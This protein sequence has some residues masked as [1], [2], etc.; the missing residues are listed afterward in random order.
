MLESKKTAVHWPLDIH[1]EIAEVFVVNRIST[2]KD[3]GTLWDKLRKAHSWPEWYPNS[4][5]VEI[6]NRETPLLNHGST[7]VWETHGMFWA[8]CVIEE[9]DEKEKRLAWRAALNG[10]TAYHAWIFRENENGTAE[11]IT[12]EC[13][14]GPF[15]HENKEMLTGAVFDGHHLRA[16][17]E[18]VL[19]RYLGGL[20]LLRYS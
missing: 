7:F 15:A 3:I 10:M 1:P 4:K 12:E 8:A 13:Q 20:L 9:Y 5:H 11:I 18:L 6:V 17:F 19:A 16:G 2:D 14:V